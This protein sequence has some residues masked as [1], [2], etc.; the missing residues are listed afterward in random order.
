MEDAII[1]NSGSELSPQN[2]NLAKL[3]TFFGV[4]WRSST[5]ADLFVNDDSS[6]PV[7][8]RLFCSSDIFIELV[9]SLQQSPT[10]LELWRHVVHSAFVYAGNDSG[11][12]ER[13]VKMLWGSGV[14]EES[15]SFRREF[16]ITSNFPEFSGVM[17]GLSIVSENGKAHSISVRSDRSRQSQI[18]SADDGS[19]FSK[20]DYEDVP[21]FLSA[22]RTI[23][24]I[25]S[26]LAD[27]LFDVRHYFI[28]AV[29]IVLYIRWAFARTSWNAPE[30]SAC[31]IID[32][33]L[34]KPTYGFIEFHKL[35]ALM[36]RY[37]FSTNIAFIP[38]NWRRS[39][40]RVVELFR[41]NPDCFSISIHGCAHTDAE[42]GNDSL[43]WLEAKAR[44]ALTHMEWHESATGI[45]HDHVMVFPQG[46]FSEAA[47]RVLK[48]TDI[49]AAVNNDTI[50]ADQTPRSITIADVWQVAVMAYD[51]FP[52]F[53]R[54]YPWAGIENFAF[55]ALLGKPLLIVIHHDFCRDSCARLIDFVQQV[56]SLTSPPAWR[57]LGEVVRRS[58]RQQLLSADLM[59]IEMYGRELRLKNRSEQSRQVI[60]K[61]RECEPESISRVTVDDQEIALETIP[62]GIQFSLELN[63]GEV[64]LVRARYHA[65]P[66]GEA[67]PESIADRARATVRRY[68]CEFRDNYLHKLR[69]SLAGR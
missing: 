58:F 55:D 13:I 62:D 64:V 24:N 33:P 61:R 46:V 18:I 44:Q 22:G 49:I 69:A 47:M 29:P 68:L 66:E 54:R 30:S 43:E 42:F 40:S 23:V 8:A 9:R 53:T 67:F 19:V 48:R 4:S 59:Q 10:L 39:D 38:W 36:R 27:G 31:L 2:A 32:D 63:P 60:V 1:I 50:S 35:L 3:L 17:T 7:Q 57:G 21:V 51:T 56:N 26:E 37:N 41:E 45:N 25:D 20:S 65:S 16:V 15:D 28:E 14:A 6:E 34:L 5:V 11:D 52:L 12:V